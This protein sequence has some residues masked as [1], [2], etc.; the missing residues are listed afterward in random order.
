MGITDSVNMFP[1]S[2]IKRSKPYAGQKMRFDYP[3][4]ETLVYAIF[5]DGRKMQQKLYFLLNHEAFVVVVVALPYHSRL[6]T[7]NPLQ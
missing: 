1:W 6:D 7:Q 3:Q 4:P 2:P 5:D